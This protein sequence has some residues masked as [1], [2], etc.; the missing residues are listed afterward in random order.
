[1]ILCQ[2]SHLI[3]L[4]NAHSQ[5]NPKTTHAVFSNFYSYAY[6]SQKEQYGQIG[7]KKS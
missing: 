6:L 4:R 2:N 5:K 3:F 1:M 7:R